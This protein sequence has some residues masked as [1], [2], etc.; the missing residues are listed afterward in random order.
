MADLEDPDDIIREINEE[1]EDECDA[2][3]QRLRKKRRGFRAAFTEIENII[4]SLI[5]ATRGADGALDRSEANR[6]ALQRAR[7][8]LEIRYE[9]LQRL[10][11]RMLTIALDQQ[12]EDVYRDNIEDATGRYTQCIASLGEL[13]L[14]LQPRQIGNVDEQA[15]TN[16]L[17]PI[18]A[19]KPSFI[20]SFDN[21]PTELAAWGL[22]FRSYFDASKLNNLPV[23][24]QQA[25]LRQGL[26]PDVWTAIKHKS[27][28]KHLSSETH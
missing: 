24:Q 16:S 18:Q 9:K 28:M 13:A 11:N 6:N 8:K 20:L 10:N 2:E 3:L 4:T 23:P 5:T 15:A 25:L 27:I 12:G 26:N 1:D 17:K 22:Q 14:D 21:T 7:E 19:L